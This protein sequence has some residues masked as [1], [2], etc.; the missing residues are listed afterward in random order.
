MFSRQ[1]GTVLT[2]SEILVPPPSVQICSGFTHFLGLGD[3]CNV[4]CQSGDLAE[5]LQLFLKEPAP[6]CFHSLS[7][8]SAAFPKTACTP[9]PISCE[10]GDPRPYLREVCGAGKKRSTGFEAPS[11]RRRCKAKDLPRKGTRCVEEEAAGRQ[12]GG[13]V[14]SAKREGQAA[15]GSL[16]LEM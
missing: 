6:N 9:L 7:L 14:P 5:G 1:A 2:L 12:Q 15:E 3:P 10:G 16:A 8:K 4:L 11:C 13:A